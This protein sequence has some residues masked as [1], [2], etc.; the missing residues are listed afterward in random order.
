MEFLYEPWQSSTEIGQGISIKG[1][2]VAGVRTSFY[3]PEFKIL[4]DAGYQNFNNVEDIFIT[5]CHADHVA[6]LPLIILENIN[7][8]KITNVYCPIDSVKLIE[9]MVEAFLACNY[10]SYN[11]PR[12]LYNFCGMSES[13]ITEKRL[14]KKRMIIKVFNSDHRVPTISYGFIEKRNKLKN[15]YLN[16]DKN[17]IIDLKKNG[18]EIT[19][20]VEHKHFLFCGDTTHRIFDNEDTLSFK[21]IIIECTFFHPDDKKSAV[22]K[23]HMHW[24]DLEKVIR[25]NTSINFYLIHISIRYKIDQEFKDTYIKDLTNVFFL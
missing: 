22:N 4:L 9:N 20:E 11:I 10:N 2:S 19:E 18:V 17:E 12:N 7:E 13:Y 15:D 14:N 8:K 23:K 16:L 6:S 1:N 21:S 5:H 3:I 25:E 24:D